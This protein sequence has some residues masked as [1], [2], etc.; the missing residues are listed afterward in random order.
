MHKTNYSAVTQNFCCLI[1]Q[2]NDVPLGRRLQQPWYSRIIFCIGILAQF[3]K[4]AFR[5]YFW[6]CTTPP[7]SLA[8]GNQSDFTQY[9]CFE[10]WLEFTNFTE[11][12]YTRRLWYPNF[13]NKYLHQLPR[14]PRQQ[15]VKGGKAKSCSLL[16]IDFS[17][18]ILYVLNI[19]MQ[20]PFHQ[21]QVAITLLLF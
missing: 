21:T 5:F 17:L 1:P 16:F 4:G 11:K 8:I 20:N 3:L 15:Q 13:Y 6:K 9:I 14:A 19:T 18:L 10:F 7:Y 2:D 12:H